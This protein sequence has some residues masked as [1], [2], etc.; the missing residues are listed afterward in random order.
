LLN[1]YDSVPAGVKKEVADIVCALAS[2]RYPGNKPFLGGSL[3]AE[4][5]GNQ[6]GDDRV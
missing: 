5:W 3:P 1:E 2:R 6:D 4:K